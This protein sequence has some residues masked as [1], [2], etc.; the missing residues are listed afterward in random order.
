MIK[1]ELVLLLSEDSS[2]VVQV[3]GEKINLAS[4][5]IDTSDFLK[6]EI[7]DKVKTSKGKVYTILKPSI[8]DI[9]R[10][11]VKRTAQVMLPKDIASI[12]ANTGIDGDSLIIDAGTGTGYLA[13]FLAKLLPKSIIVSYE[14]DKEFFKH[15]QENM[16]SA[17]VWNVKLRNKDVTKGIKEKNSDLV[18]LD[19]K[20]SSVAIKHAHKSLK[21]GGWL[22][23]YSPTVD[24][25]LKVTKALGKFKFSE[26]KIVENIER[27]WQ[28]TKTLRP[29][30]TGLMHTGFLTFVR[31]I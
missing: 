5:W 20:S 31:K 16:R 12:I 2:H 27:E 4:G 7:G 29:K 14:Y 28:L 8:I 30:T 21:I 18:V 11:R 25:L 9:L 3:S 24:H 15:A 23:I 19:L 22:A 13:V 1:G 26:M 17:G 6:K 10:K